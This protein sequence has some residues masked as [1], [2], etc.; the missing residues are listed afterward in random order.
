MSLMLV[1][2]DIGEIFYSFMRFEAFMAVKIQ[3]DVFWVV[4]PCG[5][6][7]HNTEDLNLNHHHHQS[8]KSH[9]WNLCGDPTI[10][11]IHQ[12]VASEVLVSYHNT[13]WHHNP[14]D[15]DFNCVIVL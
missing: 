2:F 14:E 4:K 1:L 11:M 13:T 5:H 7:Y 15:L 9:I 8:L 3:V 12:P 10:H 6:V